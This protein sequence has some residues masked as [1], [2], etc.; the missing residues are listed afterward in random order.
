MS[1]GR[2]RLRQGLILTQLKKMLV[3]SA[4]H[5]RRHEELLLDPEHLPSPLTTTTVSFFLIKQTWR[6]DLKF[7]HQP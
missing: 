1:G 5:G 6:F 3:A 4:T 7:N 2:D